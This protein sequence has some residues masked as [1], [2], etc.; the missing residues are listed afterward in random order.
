VDGYSRL[1]SVLELP[2][3]VGSTLGAESFA[4]MVSRTGVGMLRPDFARVG[5]LTAM[6]DVIAV[7]DAFHRPVVAYMGPLVGIHLACAKPNV[8]AIPEGTKLR[9]IYV[10]GQ[11]Q[12]FVD[13]SREVSASHAGGAL[14]EILTV[15]SIV[16]AVTE[17]LPA[18]H[19]VQIL[20]DG[21]EVDTLAGH[22]DL[23]RPLARGTAWVQ[24]S[25]PPAPVV[26]GIQAAPEKQ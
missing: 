26:G 22:V 9:A 3:A 12:A 13:L 1:T 10:D 18:V 7:A 6:L 14:E 4:P 16:N 2:V 23:R 21:R 15:Y 25:T 11:G 24:E 20:V 17:N 5:G 8:T 19:A